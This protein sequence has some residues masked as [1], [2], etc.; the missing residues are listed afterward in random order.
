VPEVGVV[1]LEVDEVLLPMFARVAAYKRPNEM[2]ADDG[3]GVQDDGLVSKDKCCRA[4]LAGVDRQELVSRCMRLYR[5]VWMPCQGA[6]VGKK[7]QLGDE[8]DPSD[9][10]RAGPR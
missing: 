10:L 8:L 1:G 9:K 7:T 4:R 2:R 5:L 3:G 6:L